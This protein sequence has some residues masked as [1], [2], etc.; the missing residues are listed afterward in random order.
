[1]SN[2]IHEL[3]QTFATAPTE[4]NAVNLGS[5]LLLRL[6]RFRVANVLIVP[7]G[8][9]GGVHSVR[10]Q[11]ETADR[12]RGLQIYAYARAAS[13]RVAFAACSGELLC[14]TEGQGDWERLTGQ[15]SQDLRIKLIGLTWKKESNTE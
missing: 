1:M 11:S 4:D 15:R 6:A 7:S 3:A 13:V 2:Q 14:S 10:V 5:A 8:A 9:E 12:R